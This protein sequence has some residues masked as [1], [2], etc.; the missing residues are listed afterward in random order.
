MPHNKEFSILSSIC[1]IGV[2]NLKE[3]KNAQKFWE[4][5]LFNFTIFTHV[6]GD[7]V[8]GGE[9]YTL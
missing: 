8:A 5:Y 6:M 7:I 9:C 2:C 3:K 1:Y 4:N